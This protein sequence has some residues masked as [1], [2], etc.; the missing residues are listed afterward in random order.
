[1]PFIVLD[2][3]AAESAPITSLGAPKTSEGDTLAS[4]RLW[5]Q[6]ALGGRDDIEQDMLDGWINDSYLDVCTSVDIDEMKGSLAIETVAGQPLYT[7][8]YVVSSTQ[9]AALIDSGLNDGGW[10]LGKV[11]KSAYRDWPDKS[12]RPETYFREGDLL[13]LYPTPDKSYFVSLDIRIRPLPLAD[14]DDSPILGQEWHRPIRLGARQ[15]A[16]DDLQ[17][18][19][20]APIAENSYTNSVR[21]RNNREASEDERRVIGSSVPGRGRPRFPFFRGRD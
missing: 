12:G 2:P 18:F 19:E 13:I 10:P 14:D 21:R 16:F 5:L 4:M 8:P 17:E 20:K 1:M 3:S 15:K 6:R 9:G 7:L 11:D